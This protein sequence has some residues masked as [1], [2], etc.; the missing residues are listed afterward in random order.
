MDYFDSEKEL[1][2]F[3]KSKK[4]VESESSL[5]EVIPESEIK[6]EIPSVPDINEDKEEHPDSNNQKV[7]DSD[8]KKEESEVIDNEKKQS[9]KKK[10]VKK[11]KENEEN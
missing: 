5:R 2:A 1:L 6:V 4:N 11:E 3:M 7:V 8:G 10:N 9:P